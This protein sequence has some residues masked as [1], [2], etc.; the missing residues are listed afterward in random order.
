MIGTWV[1]SER[2]PRVSGYSPLSIGRNCVAE[3]RDFGAHVRNYRHAV[4]AA[5]RAAGRRPGRLRN[6]GLRRPRSGRTRKR[7]A[8]AKRGRASVSTWS[9]SP[10][11]RRGGWRKAPGSPRPQGA[12]IID[13]NM[14]CPSQ[15]GHKRGLSGSALM[16][17]VDHAL[18]LIEATVSRCP[19]AGDVEDAAWLGCVQHQ[20]TGTCTPRRSCRRAAHHG[21]R[22]HTMSVLRR[23]ADWNAVRRG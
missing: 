14:G 6:D 10:A 23:K 9:S 11:A 5:G 22:S 15:A 16:R 12:D 19:C 2:E 21:P 8:R 3:P 4:P 18:T 1:E 17:D 20:R 7:R 13:I